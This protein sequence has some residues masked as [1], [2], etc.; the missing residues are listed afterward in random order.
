M[1]QEKEYYKEWFEQDGNFKAFKRAVKYGFKKVFGHT[2]E[3]TIIPRGE[4]LT[5]WESVKK[6][7]NA[8]YNISSCGCG[9][10]I[11]IE[12]GRCIYISQWWEE[13]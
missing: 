11:D 9:M 4:D 12:F 13:E 5:L 7:G 6:T 1:R 10:A 3:L 2:D 8:Q